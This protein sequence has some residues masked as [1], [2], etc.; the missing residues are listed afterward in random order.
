MRRLALQ[1]HLNKTIERG[2]IKLTVVFLNAQTM[3]ELA[4]VCIIFLKMQNYEKHE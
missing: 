3:L 2:K 1:K 4:L